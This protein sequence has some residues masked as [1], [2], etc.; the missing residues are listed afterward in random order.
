[1]TIQTSTQKMLGLTINVLLLLGLLLLSV[2]LYQKYGLAVALIVVGLFLI[3][4]AIYITRLYFYWRVSNA[5][6]RKPVR[7]DGV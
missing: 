7:G 1:M 4:S 5:R 3:A 6:N 2:G